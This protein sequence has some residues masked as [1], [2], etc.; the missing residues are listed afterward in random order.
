MIAGDRTRSSL[1][2]TVFFVLAMGGSMVAQSTSQAQPSG[3]TEA[4]LTGHAKGTF[5]VKVIPQTADEQAH[6]AGIARMSLDKQWHGGLEGMSQGEMLSSG[7]GAKGSS[8]AYVA[9]EQFTGTL[10][11]RSGSF[12]FQQMGTMTRGVPNLTITVVPD[13]GSGQLAGIAGT[14]TI[15]IADGKHSYDFEY[16]LPEGH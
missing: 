13:S 16:T 15:V 4:M 10:A 9:L 6:S 14:L 12:V 8:G 3:K 7:S 11:G 1:T 5:E 2:L